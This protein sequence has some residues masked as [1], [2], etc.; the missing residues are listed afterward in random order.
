MAICVAEVADVFDWGVV[1]VPIQLLSKL[2]PGPVTLCFK[3]FPELN[4]EFNPGLC[5][6]NE[7]EQ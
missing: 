7:N 5:N 4:P 6:E 2:L 1:T 3:K